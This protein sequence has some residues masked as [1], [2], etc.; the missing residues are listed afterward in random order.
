MSS[1]RP[2]RTAASALLASSQR[3]ISNE[4]QQSQLS[5][6]VNYYSGSIIIFF[7]GGLRGSTRYKMGMAVPIPVVTSYQCTHAQYL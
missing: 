4:T 7:N 3:D 2:G 6:V 5:A 1:S